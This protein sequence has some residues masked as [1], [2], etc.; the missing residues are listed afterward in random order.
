L[1]LV[2]GFNGHP[3]ILEILIRMEIPLGM[4]TICPDGGT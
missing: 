3:G 4:K 1:V 2:M